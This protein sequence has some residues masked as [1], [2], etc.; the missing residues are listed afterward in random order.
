M[1]YANTTLVGNGVLTAFPFNIPYINPGDI[2]VYLA[3]ILQT[4][5]YTLSG[6]TVNFT[7][8][9][10]NLATILIQRVTQRSATLVTYADASVLSQSQLNESQTQMLYICQEAFDLANS[11]VNLTLSG[12]Y[13]ANSLQITNVGTPVN[14]GDA[15]NLST[16]QAY[17][18][19]AAGLAQ[20]PSPRGT[21][22]SI[23]ISA[24]G[25]TNQLS[26]NIVNL[27]VTTPTNSLTRLVN[28]SGTIVTGGASGIP[29]GLD[30]V[31]TWLNNYWYGLYMI[32][33][34]T[35]GDTNYLWSRQ[36][37]NPTLPTGYTEWAYVSAMRTAGDGTFFPMPYYQ[38]DREVYFR[39]TVSTPLVNYPTLA[40]GVIGTWSSTVPTFSTISTGGF[41]FST[42]PYVRAISLLLSC[43]GAA[44]SGIMVRPSSINCGGYGSATPPPLSL[45]SPSEWTKQGKIEVGYAVSSSIDVVTTG[46]T[47]LVQCT[48]F[49]LGNF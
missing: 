44:S 1:A 29:G 16:L 20:L 31:N 34:P 24:A 36:W 7:I 6:T 33:N 41:N 28:Y 5:G 13:T 39:P 3:G 19:N 45:N 21:A 17:A 2:Q 18:I 47:S 8:P 32:Y 35:T 48:G 27:T 15:V 38:V 43:A 12:V 42:P 40:S 22:S 37:L 46:A 23:T 9:P 49:T 10:A 14:S 25:T 26:V 11:S 30:S 4:T